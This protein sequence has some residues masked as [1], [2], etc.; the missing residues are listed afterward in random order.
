MKRM[1]Y[2]F[3]IRSNYRV[4]N[5]PRSRESQV[6]PVSGNRALP[7]GAFWPR[8]LSFSN[9]GAQYCPLLFPALY[10]QFEL[11]HN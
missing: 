11:F 9:Q 1:L 7:A 2:P 3:V 4:Q 8:H 10:S 6:T 5:I